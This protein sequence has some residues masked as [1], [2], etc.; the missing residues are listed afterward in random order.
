M[1]RLL[2]AAAAEPLLFFVVGGQTV[3]HQIPDGV[4]AKI[5]DRALT[6]LFQDLAK[7][8]LAATDRPRGS[9]SPAPGPAA[10]DPRSNSV[11]TEFGL[12]TPFEW[13]FTRTDLTRLLA[14]GALGVK[15]CASRR[16]IWGRASLSGAEGAERDARPGLGATIE[17][18]RALSDY[19]IIGDSVFDPSQGGNS[20]RQD[21]LTPKRS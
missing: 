4:P 18:T 10:G 11:R 13:C 16:L 7:Q 9:H 21:S 5:F 15:S 19:M 8:K 1:R 6:A 17:L 14:R 3:W 20:C 12:A 2:R